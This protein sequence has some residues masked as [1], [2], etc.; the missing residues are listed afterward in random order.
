M[1]QGRVL[2]DTAQQ[3]FAPLGP[4]EYYHTQGMNTL[5]GQ[6]VRDMSYR[7]AIRLL[8]RVRHEV[9]GQ[10]TPVT[11]AAAMVEREGT[12]IQHHW[13]EWSQDVFTRQAF[14]PE[15]CPRGPVKSYGLPEEA[16]RLPRDTV[17]EA[18]T[19]Y[20][21]ERRRDFQIAV[22]EAQALYEDP[23]RT[24]NVSIDD[25]G[26]VKQ[27][28]QRRHH[29]AAPAQNTPPERHY[30]QN[31]IARVDSVEGHYT[32]NGWGTPAVLRFLIAFLLTHDLLQ[33][34][35][36][37]FF[38]DGARSLHTDILRQFQ[39]WFPSVRIILDWFHLKKKCAEK[40]SLAMRGA[41]LRNA[42]LKELL[43][44]LWLGQIDRAIAYVQS[45]PPEQIKNPADQQG[46]IGYFERNRAYMPCYALRAALDLQNSSNPGEKANDLCVAARQ[47]H[48]GMSW[49]R[50]GSVALATVTA[51]YQNHEIGHWYEEQHLKFEWVA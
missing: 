43:P 34:R 47:K 31:T 16:V 32:L 14:T 50:D 3:T 30:V 2:W 44:I 24:V 19:A 28:P 12:A 48:Q 41:A 6:M 37:Q 4:R 23:A 33:T 10:G 38:V 9:A 20:N 42:A 15:G 17:E 40:L 1:C 26:V 22:P 11:T 46:L 35:H 13:E 5:L 51:L 8:N 21:H 7:H 25:V 39:E 49:S 18:V 36:L 27:I 29:G 45:I